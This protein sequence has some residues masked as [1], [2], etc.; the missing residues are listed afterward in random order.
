[1]HFSII[2]PYQIIFTCFLILS[3]FAGGFFGFQKQFPELC[4]SSALPKKSTLVL[5][6]HQ[7]GIATAPLPPA[8]N[9]NCLL[10]PPPQRLN[11]HHQQQ[12]FSFTNNISNGECRNAEKCNSAQM[13]AGQQAP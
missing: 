10:L 13:N 7:Q 8:N 2:I 9:N 4:E 11:G 12:P 3:F 5:A 1:M 6:N